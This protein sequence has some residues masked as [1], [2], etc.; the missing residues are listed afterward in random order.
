MARCKAVTPAQDCS[1]WCVVC[2]TQKSFGPLN[3]LLATYPQK[4]LWLT[5]AGGEDE[6]NTGSCDSQLFLAVYS[7]TRREARDTGPS[8]CCV[9]GQH[10]YQV[11]HLTHSAAA[12]GGVGKTWSLGNPYSKQRKTY[13]RATNF[14]LEV[15]HFLPPN[16]AF[17]VFLSSVLKKTQEGKWDAEIN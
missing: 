5:R 13:Q 3:T 17:K 12:V 8:C 9:G 11:L 2:T 16:F 10:V 7:A 14:C 4:Y 1:A 15:A 6:A